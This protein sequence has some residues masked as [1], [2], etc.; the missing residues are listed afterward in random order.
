MEGQLCEGGIEGYGKIPRNETLDQPGNL[1]VFANLYGKI[2]YY[3]H[4]ITQ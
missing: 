4:N 3:R 1:P 2:P